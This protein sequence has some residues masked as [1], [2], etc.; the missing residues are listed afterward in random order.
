MAVKQR[1]VSKGKTKEE[2]NDNK[3]KTEDQNKEEEE[4][5]IQ[6][7]GAPTKTSSVT[8]KGVLL[9]IGKV[10][11]LLLF[12]PAFLNFSALVREEKELRPDGV[13]IDV[14]H[15]QKLFKSCEGNGT[16]TV[17]LD[18][19]RGD[20][21]D[22]WTLIFPAIAKFTTVCMYDRAGLG[23]S[24][25]IMKTVNESKNAGKAYTVERMVE[26]FHKLFENEKKPFLLV[27]ADLG[28]TVAKFY[29]QMFPDAVASTVFLN[30][31]FEGIFLG[32]SNNPWD[33]YWHG[34]LMPSLQLQHIFSAMGITRL[35]LQTGFLHEPMSFEATP[36]VV[37]NRQKYLLCK[38]GHVSSKIEESYF[39]NETLSQSRTM[40]KLRPY[41][42]QVAN[43]LIWTDRYSDKIPQDKNDVWLK[44]Q[45]MFLQTFPKPKGGPTKLNGFLPEVFFTKH[46]SIVQ[47]IKDSV[48]KWRKKAKVSSSSKY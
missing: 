13:L 39:L 26:D 23:F 1:P 19:P 45:E 18:A 3:N 20:T 21:S 25:R 22:V 11:L 31:I 9:N 24:D 48:E 8:W 33:H 47:A 41:P 15:G 32:G 35:A 7:S 17:I 36:S 4:P 46:Q 2:N 40:Q 12:V 44:S 42:E 27:G 29:T 6:S 38:P 30:P 5:K 16:P 43:T 10:L 28:A 37:K 34:S 14:R